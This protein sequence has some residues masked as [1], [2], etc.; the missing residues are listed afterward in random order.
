MRKGRLMNVSYHHHNDHPPLETASPYLIVNLDGDLLDP[1]VLS[2]SHVA[3]IPVV[4]GDLELGQLRVRVATAALHHDVATQALVVVP[5]PVEAYAV[6]VAETC[7]LANGCT[8]KK[9]NMGNIF[10]S[11]KGGWTYSLS[12]SFSLCVCSIAR[13]GC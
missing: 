2:M 7:A 9:S 10:L 5:L 6:G 3:V 12:L 4:G 13:T 11:G 1:G 8:P